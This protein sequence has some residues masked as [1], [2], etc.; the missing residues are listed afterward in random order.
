MIYSLKMLIAFTRE[1]VCWLN[2]NF[3]EFTMRIV[4]LAT[5][6]LLSGCANVPMNSIL[7]SSERTVVVESIFSNMDASQRLADAECA[8]HQ[9][10][11]RL[12]G[13]ARDYKLIYDCVH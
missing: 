12:S 4:V 8:K 7:S 11:A 2:S 1:T 9:R 6:L 5:A 3:L 13:P 10:L